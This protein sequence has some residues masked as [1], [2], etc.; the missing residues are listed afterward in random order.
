MFALFAEFS[1]PLNARV[2]PDAQISARS[3]YNFPLGGAG[4]NLGQRS[5]P[6]LP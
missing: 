4:E 1:H 5:E 2:A 3:L 6:G